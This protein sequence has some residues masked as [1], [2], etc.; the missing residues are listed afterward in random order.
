[1]IGTKIQHPLRFPNAS[2]ERPHQTTTVQ[3]QPESHN[4]Q[5]LRGWFHHS[6]FPYNIALW[7][8]QFL[9]KQTLCRTARQGS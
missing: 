8:N 1:M 7:E 6:Y 9:S 2:D 5:G 4:R 3:D